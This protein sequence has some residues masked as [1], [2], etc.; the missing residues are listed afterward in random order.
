M[1]P[2]ECLAFRNGGMATPAAF[3][4]VPVLDELLQLSLWGYEENCC[5]IECEFAGERLGDE[6]PP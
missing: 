3:L 1:D 4:G 2:Q 5:H 6:R